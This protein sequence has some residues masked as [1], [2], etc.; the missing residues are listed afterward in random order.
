MTETGTGAPGWDAIES[1]FRD[2]YPGQDSRR[3]FETHGSEPPNTCV[4]GVAAYEASGFWHLVTLGL[5]ELWAKQGDDLEASGWGF[6][7]TLKVPRGEDE[8]DPPAWAVKLLKIVGDSVYRT[9]K[10]L[11]E[12]SRLDVG[13][14]ITMPILSSLQAL[15]LTR[16]PD[17]ATLSTPNGRVDFLQVVGITSDEMEQMQATSTNEVL[18]QLAL[19]NPLLLTDPG[20]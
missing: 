19:V 16:D 18:D 13:A 11:A 5:T 1:A 8:Q 20:R 6:E 12:G 9:G 15:A 3:H 4:W 2:L 7:L 17:L 14:P 10:P